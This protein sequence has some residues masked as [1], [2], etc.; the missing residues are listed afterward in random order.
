MSAQDTHNSVGFPPEGG[1]PSRAKT[2]SGVVAAVVIAALLSGCAHPKTING[3]EYQPYGLMNEGD[4]KDPSVRYEVPFG[5]IFWA[6]VGVETIFLPVYIIGWDLYAPVSKKPAAK[7][8][9]SSQ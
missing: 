6:C 1:S 2:T 8:T 4:R 3:V 9:G 5:N 7:A